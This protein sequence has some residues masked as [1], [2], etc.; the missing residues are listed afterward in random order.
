VREGLGRLGLAER[1]VLLRIF[2]EEQ[3]Y[4]TIA[5][6]TASHR[7]AI[8]TRAFRARRRLRLLLSGS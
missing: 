1:D 6:Q 7:G 3:D 8:K 2:L 5:T 4:G